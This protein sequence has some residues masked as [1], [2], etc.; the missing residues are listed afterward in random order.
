MSMFLGKVRISAPQE[1][2]PLWLGECLSRSGLAIELRRLYTVSWMHFAVVSMS[3][4]HLFFVPRVNPFS[5]MVQYL[6]HASAYR[7]NRDIFHLSAI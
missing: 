2:S 5:K 4:F 3:F 7:F 6:S 1:K